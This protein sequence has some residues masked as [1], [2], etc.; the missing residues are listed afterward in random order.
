MW[1]SRFDLTMQTGKDKAQP[2]LGKQQTQQLQQP[3][4][5]AQSQPQPQQHGRPANPTQRYKVCMVRRVFCASI[6]RSL[7]SCSKISLKY[8]DISS[9][10]IKQILVAN[11]S[12]R[13]DDSGLQRVFQQFGHITEAFV[14]K[15][16]DG[17]VTRIFLRFFMKYS[18]V[19]KALVLFV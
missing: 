4:P 13:V 7:V 18:F 9:F 12:W 10:G 16:A 6:L 2:I 15:D 3:Q 14:V 5:Q 17:K 1:R 19:K 11:L 8:P